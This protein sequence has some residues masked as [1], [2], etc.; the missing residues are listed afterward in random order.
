MSE[1]ADFLRARIAERR[2]LAEAAS[3]GPWHANAEHDEVVASDGV[4]VA[5][6]FALSGRQLRSTVDHIVAN[7]PSG[8]I[9]DCDA[10]LRMLDDAD[11]FCQEYDND[12][13]GLDDNSAAQRAYCWRDTI[14]RNL[15]A[16]FTQHPGHKGEEWAP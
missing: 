8:V 7:D 3:P 1:I 16:A 14:H 5:G 4:T 12:L 2:A 10:K 13:T 15:A 6:G 9:A 11:D